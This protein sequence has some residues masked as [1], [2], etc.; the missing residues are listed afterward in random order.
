MSRYIDK[1]KII[2]FIKENGYVYAN[3]I[4]EF[5]EDDV[6]PVVHGEWFH[7]DGAQCETRAC[8]NCNAFVTMEFDTT[9][10]NPTFKYCPHCGAKMDLEANKD[11]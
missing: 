6:A 4:D 5:I 3:K 7:P 11:V 10:W 9:K 2:Q 1:D 8:T